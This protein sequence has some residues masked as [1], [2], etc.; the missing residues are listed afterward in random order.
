[1][2]LAERFT[3]LETFLGIIIVLLAALFLAVCIIGIA[4]AP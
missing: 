1:M 2:K 4:V 3:R